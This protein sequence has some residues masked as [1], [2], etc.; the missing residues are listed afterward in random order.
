MTDQLTRR[1]LFSVLGGLIASPALAYLPE[2]KS[3]A[4]VP[5]ETSG[6]WCSGFDFSS[7]PDGATITGISYDFD[8]LP[9]YA[10]VTVNYS[11]ET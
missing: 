11:F 5:S 1:S 9:D 7:I 8:Q 2:W 4:P 10:S 6:T 3:K